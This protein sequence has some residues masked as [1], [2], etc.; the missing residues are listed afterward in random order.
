MNSKTV[1]ST[2]KFTTGHYKTQGTFNTVLLSTALACIC[3]AG[4]TQVPL[5]AMLDTGSQ[6]SFITADKA[7]AL[8]LATKSPHPTI[9]TLGS[10]SLQSQRNCCLLPITLNDTVDVNLHIISRL[11]NATP[12]RK[13][14][15]SH[16]K[17]VLNLD[18]ANTSTLLKNRHPLGRRNNG[19]SPLRQQNQRR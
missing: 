4:G 15:T 16:M 14:D 1:E 2:G 13:I 17:H 3:D 19:R 10:V 7:K 6:A 5:R 11:T 18:F 12:S 9:Q 8:M